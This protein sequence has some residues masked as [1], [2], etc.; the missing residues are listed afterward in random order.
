MD[1]PIRMVSSD[2]ASVFSELIVETL[3]E[4][5]GRDYS[6]PRRCARHP[7]SAQ[8][9]THASISLTDYLDVRNPD[10]LSLFEDLLR[11]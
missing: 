2:D 4:S 10:P 6:L 5:N 11:C 7:E 8:S 9:Q 3:R 1:Y